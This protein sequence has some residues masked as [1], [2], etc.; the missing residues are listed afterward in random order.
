MNINAIM[1]INKLR[2]DQIKKTFISQITFKHNNKSPK[3]EQH[4]QK[5]G[6]YPTAIITYICLFCRM[7]VH[8]SQSRPSVR[9][10]KQH[11]LAHRKRKYVSL[12]QFFKI[13]SKGAF[14]S[15]KIDTQ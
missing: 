12:S 9:W 7:L 2:Q 5:L 8:G 15:S 4:E 11:A 10:S 3:Q 1:N 14:F 13:Q 6:L